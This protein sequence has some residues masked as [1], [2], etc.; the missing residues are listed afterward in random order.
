M[1]AVCRHVNQTCGIAGAME[2]WPAMTK[3]QA[4]QYLLDLAGFRTIPVELGRHY[5]ADGW[6]QS[7]MQF[8]DFLQLHMLPSASA[9]ASQVT[10]TR[11]ASVLLRFGGYVQHI[12]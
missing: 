1:Q 11:Q 8:S 6:G 9:A 10:P 4:P 12:R 3:W 7:L 2:G 5:L